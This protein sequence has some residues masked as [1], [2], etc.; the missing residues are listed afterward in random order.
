MSIGSESVLS[1]V[2]NWWRNWK[3]RRRA[4]DE[5]ACCGDAEA[6]HI[7]HDVGVAPAELRI[8]AAKWPDSSDRS[9]TQEVRKAWSDASITATVKTKLAGASPTTLLKVNV[10]TTNGIVQL[11]GTVDSDGTRQRATALAR[12]VDGVRRVVNN[13]KVEG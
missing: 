1:S 13:L 11:N 5:L 7:A 6:A 12:Q 4:L 8:L 3:T 2:A 10:E 9:W